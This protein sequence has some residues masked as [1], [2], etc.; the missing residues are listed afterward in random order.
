MNAI[1]QPAVGVGKV[2]KVSPKKR[3]EGGWKMTRELSDNKQESVA[4]Q[5]G[6]CFVK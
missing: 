2:I 1:I 3:R 4:A 5:H 6:H